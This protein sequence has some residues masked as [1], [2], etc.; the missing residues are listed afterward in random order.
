VHDLLAAAAEFRRDAVDVLRTV[1]AFYEAM[2]AHGDEAERIPT[3]GP[4]TR[5][6]L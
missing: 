3:D 4:D 6:D 1:L 2:R 5:L